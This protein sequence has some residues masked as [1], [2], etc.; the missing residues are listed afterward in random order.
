MRGFAALGML[1]T[2]ATIEPARAVPSFARQTGQPCGACH[3]DFPQLTPF[4]RSFKLRGYTAGGGQFRRTPFDDAAAAA[5]LAQYTGMPVKAPPAIVGSINDVWVPPVAVMAVVG[6]T[7]TQVPQDP[8][9]SPFQPNDNVFPSPVSVFYGGAITDHIGA[10][11]QFTF[12]GPGMGAPPDAFTH[13]WGWDNSDVRY[14][15][16][17]RFGDWDLVW[18]ITGNNNPSV[19]DVWNTTPAWKF[20]FASSTLAPTPSAKTIIDG[21]LGPGHVVSVGAYAWIND[22]VYLEGTGY[23]TLDFN[24]QNNLGVDPFGAPGLIDGAAPY[25]RA[26]VEPHWGNHSLEVG[27]FG[28]LTRIAPWLTSI[29]G[30]TASLTDK[31]TD[32]GV[33]SQYQYQGDNYWVTL[34]GSYIHESERLD[35]SFFLGNAASLN[36]QLNTLR[37]EASLAYGADNRIVATAQYFSTW[38]SFDPIFFA[39]SLGIG[40]PNSN[41]YVFELAYMPFGMSKAPLWPWFNARIGAQYIYYNEFD[42]DRVHAHDNNTF[43]L[44]AWFAM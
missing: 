36:N 38:G 29:N 20:P 34:R 4:G 11:A 17:G 43:F 37:A 16:T 21:T 15:N 44:Y 9:G 12:A 42:G 7:H 26:A 2:L 6:F 18:G 32:I 1:A 3:T 19:Q 30:S 22:L 40:I 13:N 24:T 31:Y 35:A 39:G 25:F 5:V 8:T 27:T 33:D 14:S 28:L 23:K 10:F 41:G